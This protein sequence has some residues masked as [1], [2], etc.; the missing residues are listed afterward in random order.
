[1]TPEDLVLFMAKACCFA[2]EH[3]DD[4]QAWSTEE[5]DRENRLQCVSYQ[6]ACFLAQNTVFGEEGVEWEVVIDELVAHPM[7]TE[8]QWVEILN[9]VAKKLGGWMIA[10]PAE[11]KESELEKVKRLLRRAYDHLE[12]CGFGDQ[13]ERECSEE[14][15]KELSDYFGK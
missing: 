3:I 10:V 11:S 5:I 1:M 2:Q 7:K 14:L 9:A 15:Q 4:P 6:M 13:W 8:E 12:Y